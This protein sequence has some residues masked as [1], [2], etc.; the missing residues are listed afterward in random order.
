MG[1]SEGRFCCTHVRGRR[2]RRGAYRFVWTSGRTI[3]RCST[4]PST[5]ACAASVSRARR[6]TLWWTSSWRRCARGSRG[7]WCSSKISGTRTRSGAGRVSSRATVLQRRHSGD[8]VR[9]AGGVA[10]R[11]Y[12]RRGRRWTE[13]RSSFTARGGWGW[14]RGAHRHGDG[15]TR[16][17]A[18]GGDASLLLHGLQGTGVPRRG[19]TCNRTRSRSRTTC[20][21][22]PICAA[23]LTPL[24]PTALDGRE[25]RRRGV[26]RGRRA[27]HG[28]HQRPTR[29]NAPQQSRRARR[30]ARSSRRCDGRTAASSSRADRRSPR[31]AHEGT[32]LHP[33][34]ANNAYVFPALGHA[35]VLAGAGSVSDDVFLAAA[36]SLATMTT[37]EELAS[38]EK[39]FPDF[40]SIQKVSAELTA[41]VCESWRA[42]A[43]AP[44]PWACET[45]ANTSTPS[46][47]DRRRR[48]RLA[49]NC[50]DETRKRETRDETAPAGRGEGG[51]VVRGRDEPRSSGRATRPPLCR[52]R[53][54][55]PYARHRG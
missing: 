25:H 2:S 22:N 38:G 46:F 8:G 42:T 6:T 36:E 32:T 41:R 5:R 23:R 13:Q 43:W 47:I 31:H 14:D 30:S 40:D 27:R 45:G 21:S 9:R 18:R 34:Q 53:A 50:D 12:G 55:S 16:D 33:A 52:V 54:D 7:C 29:D 15:E 28:S 35:A 20:P 37:E 26:R 24:R 17:V 49:R 39:L 19:R 10:Q 11:A 51:R 1:I 48:K 4:T 44:N 3:A